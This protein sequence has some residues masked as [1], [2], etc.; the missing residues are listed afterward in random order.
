MMGK[1]GAGDL[2]AIDCIKVCGNIRVRPFSA[3]ATP[4][5]QQQGRRRLTYSSSKFRV[6]RE[7]Q[8]EIT[9]ERLSKRW[10]R[11]GQT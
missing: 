8:A 3:T 1:H 7:F 2:F 9:L 10:M 4:G 11:K 6:K 5:Y